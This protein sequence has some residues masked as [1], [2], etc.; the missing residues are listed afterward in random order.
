[1]I[2]NWAYFYIFYFAY[3]CANTVF[4]E[5][6]IRKFTKLGDSR[7]YMHSG[8]DF[9][10]GWYSASNP[11]TENIG[12]VFSIIF[13]KN[14]ILISLAFQSIAF[15]G[16]YQ[17][18]K[19]LDSESRKYMALLLLFPSFNIWSSVASKEA[20]IVFAICI[21][22]KFV[23]DM[24]SFRDKFTFIFIF[25]VY[26]IWVYKSHYLPAILF[27]I[28]VS[29][30][31]QYFRPTHLLVLIAGVTSLT[32][33][34]IFQQKISELSFL[35]IPHFRGYGHST[36][37]VFWIDTYDVFYKAP[38]GMFQSFFG[39][40]IGEAI[41]SLNILH[42]FSFFESALLLGFLIF[43]LIRNLP[44]LPVYSF[45]IW[46]FSIFWILFANYPFGIMNPG[47]AVRYRTGY[48]VFILLI[49]VLFTS[50]SFYR[51]WHFDR[52]RRWGGKHGSDPGRVSE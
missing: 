51:N 11:I 29:K 20:I 21:I 12:T 10:T 25:S 45:L 43:L 30:M 7:Q 50:P 18:L 23:V 3:R 34:F 24:Y 49:F 2:R 8:F 13:F 39:P 46:I 37:E 9:G 22:C 31:A 33:L 19:T 28:G 47:S 44:R 4:A 48:I 32:P 26:L 36:R 5:I 6:I 27:L 42:V 52:L 1:V 16:I 14:E 38:Y 40:T 41:R 17:L 15:Y 35:I